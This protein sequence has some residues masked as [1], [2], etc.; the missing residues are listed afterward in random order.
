MHCHINKRSTLHCPLALA[1]ATGDSDKSRFNGGGGRRLGRMEMAGEKLETMKTQCV[2]GIS[3]KKKKER[4]QDCYLCAV[5][6]YPWGWVPGPPQIPKSWM[7][8]SLMYQS[9]VQ[10]ALCI[11][12]Y[13]GSTQCYPMR[14]DW[15]LLGVCYLNYG[16][17][18]NNR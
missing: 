2:Q 3:P 12:R 6:G 4:N 17:S 15:F 1:M 5:V 8:K 13:G 14:S 18:E 10:L 7:L 16:N 9:R 11:H